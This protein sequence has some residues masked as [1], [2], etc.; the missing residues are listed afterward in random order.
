[1]IESLVI[2][3][4]EGLEAALVIGIILAYLGRTGRTN[5]NTYVYQGLGL[6]ILAS[7][8]GAVIFHRI[9]FDKEVL[10]GPMYLIAGIFVGSMV[11]WMWKTSKNMKRE[12]ETKLDQITGSEDSASSQGY[13]LLVFAL[14]MVLREGI[15]T[16]LFM[17]ALSSNSNAVLS[18]IGAFAGL[19]LAVLFAVFFV[20]GSLQINL[21]RFFKVTG[22]IMLLLVLRM[23]AGS[24]HEFAEFG[25]IPMN[26]VIMKGIGYIVRD[27]GSQ[28]L[29]MMLL[30]F[31]IVMV[32][33]DVKTNIPIPN[34][35]NNSVERRK[36]KAQLGKVKIWKYSIAASAV[37]IN[38]ILGANVV[39]AMIRP[40]YDPQPLTV[41]VSDGK[42]RI[43]ETDLKENLLKKYTF[44]QDGTKVR[45]IVIKRSDGTYGTGLDACK[46]C[47]PIGYF[48]E[49]GNNANII[50]KNCNAPISIPTVGMPG[51]CNPV[52][53]KSEVRDGMVILDAAE[54]VKDTNTYK[55]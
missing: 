51:G 34:E 20:R 7:I 13:G 38:L 50:C 11:I 29:S 40:V 19:G 24:L 18:Y 8:A 12:M 28:V 33:M 39:S 41:E 1:M 48:Q 3:L 10:D 30:T 2:T 23:F 6:G 21:Q 27:T 54:L 4:R 22:L 26:P 9:G 5:L 32:L 45:F 17:A 35:I 47:G 44:V 31:P 25:V 55:K 43:P 52:S 37:L 14:F 36:I 46:I 49:E 15:E 16:V 53:V 42:V